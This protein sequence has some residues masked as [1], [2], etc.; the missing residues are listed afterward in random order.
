[1]SGKAEI[2]CSQS[3]RSK[4]FVVG[5]VKEVFEVIFKRQTFLELSSHEFLKVDVVYFSDV[6]K[7]YLGENEISCPEQRFGRIF[8]ARLDLGRVSR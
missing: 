8:A 5:K 3:E 1:M 6:M 4:D 2:I 7:V